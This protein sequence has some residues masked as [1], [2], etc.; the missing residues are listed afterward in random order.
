[1]VMNCSTQLIINAIDYEADLQEVWSVRKNIRHV[2]SN[3]VNHGTTGGS[4]QVG[5]GLGKKFCQHY[6]RHGAAIPAQPAAEPSKEGGRY[7]AGLM[8]TSQSTS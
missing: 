8:D 3:N 7:T 2:M 6:S 4:Q 5:G 1:M